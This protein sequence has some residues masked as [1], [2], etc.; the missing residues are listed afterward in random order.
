MACSS[1]DNDPNAGNT[2]PGGSLDLGYAAVLKLGK[3]G[4]LM[5]LFFSFLD[6]SIYTGTIVYYNLIS[7]SYWLI[8]LDCKSRFLPR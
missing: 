4:V 2:G 7:K 5:I 1:L 8:T 3:D 6:S